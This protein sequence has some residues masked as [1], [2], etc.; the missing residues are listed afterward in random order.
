[1]ASVRVHHPIPSQGRIAIWLPF[2]Q[3]TRLWLREVCGPGTQPEFDRA[4][5]AWTV[6]RPHFRKVVEAL[7]RRCRV[8]GSTEN[9]WG[10][11]RA[12]LRLVVQ[13]VPDGAERPVRAETLRE[14]RH[15]VIAA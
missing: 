9:S 8:L 3:G 2:A 5:N 6:A 11:G 15:P 14:Q 13:E 7:A 4:R 10:A 12:L 1:M